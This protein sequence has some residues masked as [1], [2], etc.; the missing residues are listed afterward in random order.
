MTVLYSRSGRNMPLYNFMKVL[1]FLLALLVMCVSKSRLVYLSS[2]V[3]HNTPLRNS[4]Q[5]F[6]KSSLSSL[7]SSKNNLVSISFLAEVVE[8]K[9]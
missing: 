8:L 5:R 4:D 1:S 7:P 9:R 6:D 2:V 3:E